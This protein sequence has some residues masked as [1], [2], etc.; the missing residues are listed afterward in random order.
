MKVK[1][2]TFFVA[3]LTGAAILLF[4]VALRYAF[5]YAPPSEAQITSNPVSAKIKIPA[6]YPEQLRIPSIQVTAKVQDVGLTKNS[7]MATPNNFTDVGWYKYGVLPGKKGSAIVAGHVNDGIAFPAVF[8]NLHN[9]NLGDDI[10]YR[11][12]WW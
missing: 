3:V 2:K 9:V 6:S 12:G 4:G 10:L 1:L 7:N 5:F 11:H 8:A